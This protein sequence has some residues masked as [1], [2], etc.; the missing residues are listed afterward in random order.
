MSAQSHEV[1]TNASATPVDRPQAAAP[2]TASMPAPRAVTLGPANWRGRY[3]PRLFV[4]D[5]LVLI[6]VVYGTQ[7]V[8]FG[9]GNAQVA[10]RGDS[11]ISALSYWV[12]SANLVIVWV[13]ARSLMDLDSYRAVGTGVTEYMRV[14]DG[15]PRL[16]GGIAI[17]T[18]VD[19]AR[20]YLLIAHRSRG[21]CSARV[22]LVV[23]P[24]QSVSQLAREL[25]RSPSGRVP[26]GWRVRTLRQAGRHDSR[27]RNPIMGNVDRVDGVIAATGAGTVAVTSTDELPADKVKQISWSIEVGRQHLVLAPSIVDIVGPRIHTRPVAGPRLIHVGTPTFGRG[28]RISKRTMD[29]SLPVVGVIIISPVPLILAMCARLLA[30]GPVLFRETRFSLRGHEFTM[31]KFRSMVANTEELLPDLQDQHDA[32]HHFL[33]KMTNDPRVT[34]V[35][36][37]MRRFRLDGLPQMFNVIDGDMTLV[38]QR[39]PLPSEVERYETHVHRR[40]L[41][42]PGITR[43]WQVGGR[44]TLSWDDS[45]RVDFAYVENWPLIG[46]IVILLRTAGAVLAPGSSAR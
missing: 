36:R 38:G 7:L 1:M 31:L 10:V 45:V 12:F 18:R 46:D 16:F 40:F 17:L 15:S 23:G 3:A 2:H 35:G 24:E 14:S 6:W 11:R 4:S 30:D 34:P 19:V 22:L 21:R 27:H 9:F 8:W 29:L 41:A 43:A 5:L 39:P 26:S 20:G 44:S 42:K 33:F 32:G 28:Q 37:F 25:D 13:W